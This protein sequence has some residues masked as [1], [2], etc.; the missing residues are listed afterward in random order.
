MGSVRR[1]F[2]KL[3]AV[4]LV[5]IAS[6]PVAVGLLAGPQTEAEI[7]IAIAAEKKAAA[8]EIV[9]QY[10]LAYQGM[11]FSANRV[12]KAADD[13]DVKEFRKQGLYLA[14]TA[15]A[16]LD[17]PKYPGSGKVNMHWDAAMNEC[18]KAGNA[19]NAV[20]IRGTQLHMSK[21]RGEL[22]YAMNFA[23]DLKLDQGTAD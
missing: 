6:I 9:R 5:T 1:R 13:G 11:G 4:A 21:C 22:L 18:I 17:L 20:D 7:D 15:Q 3:I 14:A 2:G 23:Y 12:A 16:G 19:A 10:E 8:D